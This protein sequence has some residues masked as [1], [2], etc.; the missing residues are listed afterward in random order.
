MREK[1]KEYFIKKS[2]GLKGTKTCKSGPSCN[3]VNFTEGTNKNSMWSLEKDF[4]FFDKNNIETVI[5]LLDLKQDLAL[6]HILGLGC[7]IKANCPLVGS[8]PVGG[9]PFLGSF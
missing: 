8:E 4:S 9:V 3:V 2:T 5:H 7:K 1:K 6:V